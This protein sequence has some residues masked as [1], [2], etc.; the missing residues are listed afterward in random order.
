M[1]VLLKRS[2]F[3]GFYFKHQKNNKVACFIPGIS[4]SN[5]SGN[6]RYVLIAI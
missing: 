5:Y 4:K 6:N 3:H 1:I 2:F